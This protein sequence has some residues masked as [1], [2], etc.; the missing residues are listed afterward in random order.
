M[1][2]AKMMKLYRFQN[3]MLKIQVHITVKFVV[4]KT[5]NK[6]NGQVV[7]AESHRQNH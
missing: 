4:T 6:K 2:D 5:K 1:G 3:L 7:A